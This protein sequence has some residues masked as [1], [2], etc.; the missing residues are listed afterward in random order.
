MAERYDVRITLLSQKRKCHNGHEVGDS[1]TC[2]RF[3]PEGMC[4]GSFS[5]LLPYITTLEFGG[6][7]PWEA[8]E[9]VAHIACPDGEVANVFKLER[10]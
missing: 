3:T 6:D 5:A 10:V 7:F 1:W 9:G 8:E 4:L 2:G